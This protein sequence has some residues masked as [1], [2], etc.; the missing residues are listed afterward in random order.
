MRLNEFSEKVRVYIQHVQENQQQLE[1]SGAP[2][3]PYELALLWRMERYQISYLPG[4][5]ADQPHI[6]ML[7]FDIIH[8]ERARF[9]QLKKINEARQKEWVEQQKRGKDRAR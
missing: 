7:C 5:L 9:E 4:G 3:P 6:L 8:N 2:E 1:Q